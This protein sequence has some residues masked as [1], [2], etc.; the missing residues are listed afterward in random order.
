MK[1]TMRIE[2]EDGREIEICG[3][4]DDMQVNKVPRDVP[5][6]VPLEFPVDHQFVQVSGSIC[7]STYKVSAEAPRAPGAGAP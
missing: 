4:S 1:I 7:V 5:A 3:T 6:P 2:T